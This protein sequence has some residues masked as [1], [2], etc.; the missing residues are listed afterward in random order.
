MRIRSHLSCLP[1]PGRSGSCRTPDSRSMTFHLSTSAFLLPSHPTQRRNLILFAV[2]LFLTADAAREAR[3]RCDKLRRGGLRPPECER[4]HC[5]FPWCGGRISNES[6]KCGRIKP[7]EKRFG[8]QGC[9]FCKATENYQSIRE[10][11]QMMNKSS[12][13][14]I[15]PLDASPNNAEAEAMRKYPSVGPGSCETMEDETK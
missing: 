4:G 8:F 5:T 6:W 9:G 2:S 12:T 13:V 3:G 7:V 14:V 1:S 11:P 15:G 10:G